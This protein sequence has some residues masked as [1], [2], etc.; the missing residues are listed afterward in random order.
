MPQI[1]VIVPV[2]NVEA[3]VSL[4]GQHPCAEVCRFELILVDDDSLDNL[5]FRRSEEQSEA[6]VWSF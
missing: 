2:Y 3:S 6:V 5:A 4:R 1:R